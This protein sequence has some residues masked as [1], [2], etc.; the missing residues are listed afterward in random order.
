MSC[1]F[2]QD[3]IQEYLEETI[4]PLEKIIL[5]EHLKVCKSCRKELTELKLL[6]WEITDIP[7]VDIPSEAHIVRENVLNLIRES[8]SS[9]IEKS[10]FTLKNYIAM[11]SN[12]VDTAS[13]FFKF[14]PG[15]KKASNVLDHLVIDAFKAKGK[16]SYIRSIL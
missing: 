3:L 4:D 5:L 13:F 9:Y 7:G 2:D 8:K 14:V 6:Y 11:Q 1:S 15:A 16:K 10:T 12:I